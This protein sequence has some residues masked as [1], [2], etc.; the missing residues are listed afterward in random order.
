MRESAWHRSLVDGGWTASLQC[1]LDRG[2]RRL[3]PV[4]GFA[5][6]VA[7]QTGG[8]L[9]ARAIAFTSAPVISRL[10]SPADFGVLAGYAAA[11]TRA[12]HGNGQ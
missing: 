10:H 1:R 8:T 9:A 11:H 7:V 4:R 2:L 3:L 6:S 12:A 5:R